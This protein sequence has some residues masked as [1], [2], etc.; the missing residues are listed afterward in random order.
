V[1]RHYT[2]HARRR[3]ARPSRRPPRHRGATESSIA[4]SARFSPSAGGS[5][6]PVE[7]GAV[8]DRLRA[9][10]TASPHAVTGNVCRG[11]ALGRPGQ[12]EKA[13]WAQAAR[14][15]EETNHRHGHRALVHGLLR[16]R[17]AC[18]PREHPPNQH[19]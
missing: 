14:D 11:A 16:K 3:P 9:A 18:R 15:E 10:I 12:Q 5:K 7:P 4:E 8:D 13:A 17:T 2:G 19:V 6:Q 1:V